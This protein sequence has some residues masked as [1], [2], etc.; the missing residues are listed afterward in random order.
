MASLTVALYKKMQRGYETPQGHA[1]FRLFAERF[2]GAM[3]DLR[4]P[5]AIHVIPVQAC[6]VDRA[7][8][9][10]PAAPRPPTGGNIQLIDIIIYCFCH[11]FVDSETPERVKIFCFFKK[12]G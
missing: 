4:H 6:L 2:N 12:N 11:I 7:P 8:N 3:K 5:T 10:W 1:E 9:S